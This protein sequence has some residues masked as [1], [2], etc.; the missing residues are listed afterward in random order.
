VSLFSLTDLVISQVP[1]QPNMLKTRALPT[2]LLHGDD[3]NC[4]K[5]PPTCDSMFL[6]SREI[7]KLQPARWDESVYLHQQMDEE[8]CPCQDIPGCNGIAL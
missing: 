8:K 1:D 4:L 3:Q 5:F 2:S 7:V 6:N